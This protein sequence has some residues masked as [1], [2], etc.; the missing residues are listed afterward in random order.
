MSKHT[1]EGLKTATN[2]FLDSLVLPAVA[3]YRIEQRIDPSKIRVSDGI[4]NRVGAVDKIKKSHV[5]EKDRK[6]SLYYENDGFDLKPIFAKITKEGRLLLD[7][8]LLYC[9]R[10]NKTHCFVDTTEFMEVYG[11]SSRTTV[12][13]SK[14]NLVNLGFI[15][16]TAYQGWYWINPKFMFKGDRLKCN[17]LSDIFEIKTFEE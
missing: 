16:P 13:N 9:L 12:W 17:E 7:Y 1:P 14:K 11:I 8:I 6:V 2:P 10:E 3:L 5:V 4:I 15:S